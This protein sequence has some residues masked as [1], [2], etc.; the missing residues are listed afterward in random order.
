[1][2]MTQ[3]IH[4]PFRLRDIQGLTTLVYSGPKSLATRSLLSTGPE[5]ALR[6]RTI[7]LAVRGMLTLGNTTCIEPPTTKQCVTVAPLITKEIAT[8]MLGIHF[9]LGLRPLLAFIH[10]RP[11]FQQFDHF[12]ALVCLVLVII[13]LPCS[14]S[15]LSVETNEPNVLSPIRTIAT[16]SQHYPMVH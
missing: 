10:L 12:I 16:M 8:T 5:H 13:L 11:S 14:P 9:T 1:M 15:V 6:Q 2:R 3:N 7:L 4:H